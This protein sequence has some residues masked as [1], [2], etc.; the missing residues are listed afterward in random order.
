MPKLY[1]TTLTTTMLLITN[2]VQGANHDRIEVLASQAIFNT[3]QR[4][5]QIFKENIAHIKLKAMDIS[6]E[7]IKTVQIPKKIQAEFLAV[8]SGGQRIAGHLEVFTE[9]ATGSVRHA[10]LHFYK[11]IASIPIPAPK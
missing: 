3:E 6:D 10:I 7:K 8:I 2:L 5:N 1:L 9:P 11:P 4:F